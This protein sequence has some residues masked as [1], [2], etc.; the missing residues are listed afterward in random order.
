MRFGIRAF[1]NAQ[2]SRAQ[3]AV[4]NRRRNAHNASDH[5]SRLHHHTS[6]STE[7]MPTTKL[8]AAVSATQAT[9]WSASAI[10]LSMNRAA[11]LSRLRFL[12]PVWFSKELADLRHSGRVHTHSLTDILFELPH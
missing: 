5:L 11:T 8:N 3:N 4:S 1:R 9:I 12:K 7:V 10:H 6:S 2:G